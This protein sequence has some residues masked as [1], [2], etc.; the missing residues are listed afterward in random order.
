MNLLYLIL[1]D[2]NG[3]LLLSL[4]SIYVGSFAN[5]SIVDLKFT[6]YCNSSDAYFL[7]SSA[8][9]SYSKGLLLKVK[10]L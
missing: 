1:K 8:N 7:Y 9:V 10:W 5:D 2:R 3:I 4:L 6:E